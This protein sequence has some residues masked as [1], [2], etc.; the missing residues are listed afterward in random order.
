VS[1]TRAEVVAWAAEQYGPAHAERRVGDAGFAFWVNTQEDAVIEGRAPA[2]YGGVSVVVLG[3]T[4]EFWYVGSHPDHIGLYDATTERQLRRGLGRRDGRIKPATT[5]RDAV[6]RA[7]VVAWTAAQHGPAH[8]EGRV[9]DS[10]FAFWV[11][12][13]DDAVIEG[14]MPATAGAVS[15]VVLKRT[16][17]YWFA[18]SHP[19]HLALRAATGEREL[20][21]GLGRPAGSLAQQQKKRRRGFF[22]H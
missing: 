4:G 10:G 11:N 17:E 12:T 22:R 16:G 8:A 1:L 14:R 15:V 2:V 18:G 20:R 3:R 5:S 19:D 7:E 13:Q 6:S 9:G 21:A